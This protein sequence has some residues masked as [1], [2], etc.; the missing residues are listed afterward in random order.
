MKLFVY[1][2]YANINLHKKFGIYV[3][4]FDYVLNYML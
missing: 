3:V 4:L 2:L 1:L